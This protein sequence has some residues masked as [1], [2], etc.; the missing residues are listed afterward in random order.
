MQ[1]SFIET[2]SMLTKGLNL[3]RSSKNFWRIVSLVPFNLLF[4][5]EERQ[6]DAATIINTEV[7]LPPFIQGNV[8]ALGLHKEYLWLLYNLPHLCFIDLILGEL[9]ERLVGTRE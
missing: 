2:Q 7:A 6:Y 1:L 4:K 9:C 8:S 5:S 3:S